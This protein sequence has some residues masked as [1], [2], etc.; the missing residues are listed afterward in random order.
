MRINNL[1]IRVLLSVIVFVNAALAQ[2]GTSLTNP[3]VRNPVDSAT[4]PSTTYR[5][6]LYASPNPIDRSS[7]L[8]VTGNIGTNV[9]DLILYLLK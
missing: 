4:I 3:Y 8:V 6:G 1:K 5:S 7:N 9:G 2:N